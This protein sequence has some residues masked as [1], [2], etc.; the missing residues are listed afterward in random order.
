MAR[1]SSRVIARKSASPD[2]V[3]GGGLDSPFMPLTTEAIRL[4]GLDFETSGGEA[5]G[6]PTYDHVRRAFGDDPGRAFAA[7]GRPRYPD[8]EYPVP[9]PV[10]EGFLAHCR[11]LPPR[12]AP[13]GGR[14]FR[15]EPHRY[16][17]RSGMAFDMADLTRDVA[18]AERAGRTILWETEAGVSDA[19]ARLAAMR[20]RLTQAG[21]RL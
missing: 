10:R 6:P 1:N 4:R 16:A 21:Y 7:W 12:P 5:D 8:R 14:A 3:R 19:E 17:S 18:N 2:V 9:A 20:T 11:E 13:A 15:V